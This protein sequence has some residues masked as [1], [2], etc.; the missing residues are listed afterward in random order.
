ML[1]D[2]QK[3]YRDRANRA[4]RELLK[5][6]EKFRAISDGSGKRYRVCVDFVLSGA[7]EKAV[8]FLNWFE[9]E[10]PDDVGEPAFLLYAAL[11][12]YRVGAL[13][14]AQGYLLDTMLSNIYLLPYL[15]SRPIP[16]QDM[17]HSSNWAQPD[18]I[19]NIKELLEGPTS[20]E[21]QWFQE[22]FE[23]ERF[24]SIRSKY[25]ETFH[26]LQ[27]VK[28]LDSRGRILKGWRDYVSSSRANEI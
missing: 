8:E 7:P 20:Q 28:D 26:A 21:R 22:R 24:T 14:K 11:A 9:T 17:W 5:E 2:R 13:G 12:Y 1:S 4:R 25:I 6:Q 18:Y 19:E 3:K 15:F 27:H 23:D 16:K 10:F